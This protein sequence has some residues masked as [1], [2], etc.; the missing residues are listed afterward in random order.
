[1]RRRSWPTKNLAGLLVS[2]ALTSAAG[3]CILPA[4]LVEVLVETELP[5]SGPFDLRVWVR[6]NDRPFG[7]T[8]PARE[9]ATFRMVGRRSRIGDAPSFVLVP[10]EGGARDAIVTARVEAEAE[11]VVLRRDVRFRFTPNTHG[12]VRIVLRGSCGLPDTRCRMVEPCTRQAVCEENGQTCG[13][14]GVCVTPQVIPTLSRG[15]PFNPN[16]FD[17]TVPDAGEDAGMPPE[18]ACVP[19]CMG[20]RCGEPNGCGGICESGPCAGGEACNLGRCECAPGFT[21]CGGT[22]RPDADIEC[23]S[24]MTRSMSCGTCGSRM[25]R[26]GADCRWQNGTCSGGGTCMPGEMQS[27]PCGRCGTRSRSCGA[28]CNWGAWGGC[29]GEGVCTAGMTESMPCG[30]CG[31]QTRM[32]QADCRWGT[33]SACGGSGPCR[34]GETQSQ[35]CGNCGT[36]SRTCGSTCQW[37]AFGTC[38]GQGACAPGSTRAGCDMCGVETCTSACT[39]GACAPRAGAQCLH[40]GGTNYRSCSACRSGIQFCLPTSCVWSTACCTSGSC[41]RCL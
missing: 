28:D 4:T 35:A 32:C 13:D 18:D 6:N 37:P 14:N 40:R 29:S 39:W 30:N 21:S 20:R 8:T 23:M 15:R 25:D 33:F 1:M 12:F 7:A 34:P 16:S 38:T 11:G 2:A 17:A 19:N 3:G 27:E 5:G 41:P 22:C 10:R 24:G 36:Q 26:C 31:T 9:T